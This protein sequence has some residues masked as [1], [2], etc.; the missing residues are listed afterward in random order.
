M[1]IIFGIEL[2]NFPGLQSLRVLVYRMMY[3]IGKRAVIENHV[4][5]MR[6]HRRKDG[7]RLTVGRHAII[8]R[9]VHIDFTGEVVLGND[10]T[11]S[12]GAEIY[13]HSH[14]IKAG[15]TSEQKE[16]TLHRVE[17]KDGTWVGAHAIILPGVRSIGPNAVIGAGAVVTKDVPPN[18]VVAGNPA[19]VVRELD[20]EYTV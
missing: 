7:G 8:A 5:F 20:F 14:P 10:V 13:S 11:L 9:D 4:R 19:R 15:F 12:A 18:T 6:T 1:Q 2:F 17:I 16:T 3:R